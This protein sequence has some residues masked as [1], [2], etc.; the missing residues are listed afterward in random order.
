[1]IFS[2]RQ[3]AGRL[4]ADALREYKD[5]Q[6]IIVALPRGGVPVGYEIAKAFHAQLTVIVARKLGAPTRPE[7]GIGAIAE[8]DVCILNES[9]IKR[10]EITDSELD[11]LIQYE[12]E[13]LARRVFLYRKNA[14][15][16]TLKDAIVLLVD[17]GLATGV[18]ASAALVTIKK[19]KPKQ[20]IFAAPVCSSDAAQQINT[21]VTTVC[22]R[23]PTVFRAVGEW[24]GDFEQVT[25][26]EVV[27]FLQNAQH[28]S[29]DG[30]TNFKKSN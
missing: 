10:L 3:E 25:D 21:V 8:G 7:F 22:L 5:K 6:P 24:Y 9:L 13:E 29:S 23:T 16:P 17:D 20:I 4:L 27:G 14:H 11:A 28:F 30:E 19:H 12:K 26:E 2:D 18:T 1:M 15:F